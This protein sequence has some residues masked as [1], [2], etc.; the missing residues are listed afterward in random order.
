MILRITFIVDY[1]KENECTYDF[2]A[3]F[4]YPGIDVIV[5]AE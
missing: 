1:L 2:S 3:W 4:I 5:D